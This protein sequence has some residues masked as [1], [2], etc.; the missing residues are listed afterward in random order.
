MPKNDEKKVHWDPKVKDT[1]VRLF[2]K[3]KTLSPISEDY[4]R[5]WKRIS[6]YVKTESWGELDT[7][8][9]INKI[10]E[11]KLED[12]FYKKG[13]FVFAR[14]LSLLDPQYLVFILNKIPQKCA[15]TVFRNNDYER[16]ELF[17]QTQQLTKEYGRYTPEKK[18]LRVK[19]LTYLLELDR[20]GI[21]AFMTKN[22]DVS[23]MTKD[24]QDEYQQA[25]EAYQTNSNT[26]T[27]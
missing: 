17:L 24:I 16:L 6:S 12:F 3:K 4:S 14:G 26:K 1:N 25:L 22:K 9:E 5:L 23:F 7:F 18:A 20:E 19:L 8:L 2:K 27:L 11:K 21:A 10:D 15:Q 13:I